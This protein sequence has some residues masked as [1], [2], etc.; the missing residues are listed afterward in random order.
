MAQL[1]LVSALLS[2]LFFVMWLVTLP[3]NET[4]RQNQRNYTKAM[5]RLHR[6]YAKVSIGWAILSAFCLILSLLG[7]L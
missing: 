6:A 1:A 7:R 4:A 3:I 2:G 5:L